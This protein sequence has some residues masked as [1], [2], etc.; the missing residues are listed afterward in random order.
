MAVLH[1]DTRHGTL[2][3]KSVHA[4][5]KDLVNAFEI[6]TRIAGLWFRYCCFLECMKEA[7]VDRN[8]MLGLLHSM[9]QQIYFEG[10]LKSS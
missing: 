3:L 1:F 8:S 9:Y 10:K 6:S 2:S 5:A 7:K 4:T